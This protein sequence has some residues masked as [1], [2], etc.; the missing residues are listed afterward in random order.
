MVRTLLRNPMRDRCPRTFAVGMVR[1][2][3]SKVQVHSVAMRMG[4][5]SSL[6]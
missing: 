3:E 4:R 2:E 6:A 1:R 5:N